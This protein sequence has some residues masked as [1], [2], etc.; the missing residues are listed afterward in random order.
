M[1]LNVFDQFQIISANMS[2]NDSYHL[3]NT[4]VEYQMEVSEGTITHCIRNISISLTYLENIFGSL[5]RIVTSLDLIC[6]EKK[7]AILST[8][9]WSSSF[10]LVEIKTQYHTLQIFL[11]LG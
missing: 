10:N 1:T 3:I 7:V 4:P 11:L 8:F 2:L 5:R 9:S 6:A